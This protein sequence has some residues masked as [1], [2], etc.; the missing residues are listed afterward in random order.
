MILFA[1]FIVWLM[2]LSSCR[3]EPIITQMPFCSS[4]PPGYM[5][6]LAVLFSIR[7]LN[8]IYL[9]GS[10]ITIYL[11]KMLNNLNRSVVYAGHLDY[12]SF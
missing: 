9:G 6:T 1:L 12:Q 11:T 2:C 5:H 8:D 7:A 3:F 4:I 10:L